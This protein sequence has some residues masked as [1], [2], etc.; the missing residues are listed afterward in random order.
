V[1]CCAS[2]AEVSRAA[3]NTPKHVGMRFIFGYLRI[4]QK[5]GS[6]IVGAKRD[7]VNRTQA[8]GLGCLIIRALKSERASPAQSFWAETDIV[9]LISIGKGPEWR[10]KTPQK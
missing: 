1:A 3:I 4:F 9:R 6:E 5:R 8:A 2:A 7:G 10:R